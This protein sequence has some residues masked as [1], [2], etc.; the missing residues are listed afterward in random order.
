MRV[1]R[2][3]RALGPATATGR[4]HRVRACVGFSRFRPARS[5]RFPADSRPE[6]LAV[7]KIRPEQRSFWWHFD[8]QRIAVPR[9]QF[10]FRVALWVL[11]L[12]CYSFAIQTPERGWGPE[13]IILYTQL[14]GYLVEDIV[15][16]CPPRE[17][18]S[19]LQLIPPPADLQ[20]R[21]LC[22]DFRLADRQLDDLFAVPRRFRV[23]PRASG[24]SRQLNR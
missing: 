14:L 21:H 2:L 6:R 11:F 13:D 24:S 7:F 23:R 22:D 5:L 9:Y 19:R 10:F 20:D 4:Q 3:E 17:R 18:Q 8:P 16:V 1:R 15:K 12:I